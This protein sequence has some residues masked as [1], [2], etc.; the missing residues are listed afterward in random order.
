MHYHQLFILLFLSS[1][2]VAPLSLNET[3]RSTGAGKHAVSASHGSTELAFKWNYGLTKNFDIG[4]QL[5]NFSQGVRAKYSLLNQAEG[6][7]LAVAAGSGISMGGHHYY[8]DAIYSAR[9][10]WFEP[11][12]AYRF[13]WINTDKSEFK[14]DDTDHVILKLD[15]DHFQ[16]GQFFLGTRFHLSKTFFASIEISSL[17]SMNDAKMNPELFYNIGL[18][19]KF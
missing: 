10:S 16:Y 12:L 4:V 6:S 7:S 17:Q 3:A 14:N 13:V 18:G 15:A 5:E 11:Y 1:C 2:A 19:F 8:L 9:A